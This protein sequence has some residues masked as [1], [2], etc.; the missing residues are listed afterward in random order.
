[1]DPTFQTLYRVNQCIDDEQHPLMAFAACAKHYVGYSVPRFVEDAI[2]V[3][4]GS[5]RVH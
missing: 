5:G 2:G 3:A 4:G 1:M